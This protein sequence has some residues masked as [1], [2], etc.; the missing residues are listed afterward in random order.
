MADPLA[1]TFDILGTTKALSAVELLLVALDSKHSAIQERAVGALL[2]RG[3]TRCQTEVIR[4]YPS[5]SVNAR[6][7][8][9]EQG[10][11][12]SGTLRQC[13]LHGDAELRSNAMKI[14]TTAECYDQV[15]T[16]LQILEQKGDPYQESA[17]QTLQEL[18]NRLFEH[19]LLGAVR[20]PGDRFQRNVPQ[21][22]QMVLSALDAACNQFVTLAYAREVIE[23]VLALGDPENFVV[24]KLLLQ[25]PPPCREM[26]NKLL[27]TS[28][29]PGVMRLVMDFMG[30][31]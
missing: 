5:L 15:P 13:L 25:S 3:A 27:L 10:T 21:V 24:R 8:L 29:H 2:R 16:L 23:C 30:Q 26:S 9:E 6:K 17:C 11:R 7:Y 14:V 18:V 1:R 22:R 4:R 31:N 28:K 20:K 19:T 12:I